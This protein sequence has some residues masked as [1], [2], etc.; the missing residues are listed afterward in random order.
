V[1]AIPPLPV[2]L[3]IYAVTELRAQWLAALDA[4]P[5]EGDCVVDASAVAEVD[6][7]GVQLLVA[8]SRQLAAHERGLRLVS[9]TAALRDACATLGLS[10][11]LEPADRTAE[12]TP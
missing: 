4:G 9:P 1:P 6:G 8:L 3:T 10:A 7:A 12:V 11:L 5:P 2:E